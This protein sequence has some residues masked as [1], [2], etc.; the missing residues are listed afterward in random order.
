[1]LEE[2]RSYSE[3]LPQISAVK[4][5]L[6]S[7]VQFVVEDLLDGSLTNL[8]R[9]KSASEVAQDGSLTAERL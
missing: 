2:A 7:A 5:G 8:P 4:A 3:V 9:E 6:G 1:M